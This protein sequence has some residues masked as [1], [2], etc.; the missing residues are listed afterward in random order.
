MPVLVRTES[1]GR[2]V[3]VSSGIRHR[4]PDSKVDRLGQ[5]RDSVPHS[6]TLCED[7][8]PC[9]SHESRGRLARSW[10]GQQGSRH[11]LQQG[12]KR[13][14]GIGT[15]DSRQKGQ[16]PCSRRHLS[17]RLRH[18]AFEL[19]EGGCVSRDA[20]C[21]NCSLLVCGAEGEWWLWWWSNSTAEQNTH[22]HTVNSIA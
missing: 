6:S 15:N 19:D 13:C 21:K 3:G 2:L 1:V 8:G 12:F 9:A 17:A 4:R 14:V 16:A 11:H 20:V 10:R 5:S 18:K 7:R 22:T